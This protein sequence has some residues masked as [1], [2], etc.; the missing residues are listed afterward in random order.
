MIK[1]PL[2]E[3]HVK[4]IFVHNINPKLRFIVMDYVDFYFLNIVHKVTQIEECM[5]EMGKL[6]YDNPSKDQKNPY[7]KKE[8]KHV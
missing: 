1:E 5:V 3:P 6:K 4:A 2:L 8:D 7:K